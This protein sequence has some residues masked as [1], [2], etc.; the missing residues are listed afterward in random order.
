M[1]PSL[2]ADGAERRRRFAIPFDRPC[3]LGRP[4]HR[5][6]RERRDHGSIMPAAPTAGSSKA[7]TAAL[8]GTRF[9]NMRRPRR[10]A[11]SPIAPRRYLATSGSEPANRIRATTWRAATA[12]SIPKTAG[13]PGR[14]PGS[15]APDPISSISIDPRESA[16]RGRRRSRPSVQGRPNARRLRHARRGAHWTRTLFVGPSSGVSDMVRVP[17]RPATLFAGMYQI[18]RQPWMMTSGGAERR[19]LSLGRRRLVVAQGERTRGFPAGLTGRI[20]LA[21]A[22]GGRMYAIVQSKLGDLWRS[23]DGGASWKAM[24]HSPY[25]GERPFYFSRIFVDPVDRD[26]LIDVGLVLIDERPTAAGRFASS[27][28]MPDGTTTSRGGRVTAVAYRGWER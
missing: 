22:R 1:R 5:R 16:R 19:P 27:P 23:D 4:H 7:S 24:P 18:R 13:R 3:D 21:A 15:T 11:R 14:M 20:G 6:G 10:S 12:F 26:R 8:R 28:R 2:S 25:V 9:S 17:D